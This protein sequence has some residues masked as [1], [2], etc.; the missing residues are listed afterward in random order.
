MLIGKY[1]LVTFHILFAI[2]NFRGTC[3]SIEMLQRYMAREN[4]ITPVLN[5]VPSPQGSFGGLSSPNKAPSPPN[6]NMKHYKSVEFLSI[7]RISSH[8]AQTQN[9][10]TNA[11]PPIEIFLA[12]VLPQPS[13]TATDCKSGVP[14]RGYSY[15]QGVR[16]WTSRDTKVLGS[17]SSLYIS[18]R[19]IYISKFFWGY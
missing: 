6:W 15:P 12:T 7:F 1:I 18:Y 11:N 14:N 17:Q 3:S 4:L 13:A 9:P 5:S 16:D 10:H 2:R 8:P 19:A